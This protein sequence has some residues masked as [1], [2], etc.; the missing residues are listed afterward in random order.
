MELLFLKL[1]VDT[2]WVNSLVNQRLK[3]LISNFQKHSALKRLH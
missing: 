2:K 1:K 3:I